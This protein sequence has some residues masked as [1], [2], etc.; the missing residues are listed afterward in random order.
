MIIYM[1][2]SDE[3]KLRE[4]ASTMLEQKQFDSP[5]SRNKP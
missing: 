4:L 3:Q 5:N 1:K 2:H